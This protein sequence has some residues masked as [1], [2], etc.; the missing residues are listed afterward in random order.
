M[1]ILEVTARPF[2]ERFRG[3]GERYPSIIAQELS[4]YESVVTAYCDEPAGVGNGPVLTVPYRSLNLRPFLD[5]SNPLPT[6]NTVRMVHAYLTEHRREI[7]FVHIHNLRTAMSTTWL[8]LTA[9]ARSRRGPSIILTD[10]GSRFFPFPRWSVR[11]VKYYAA[12]SAHSLAQLQRW[13]DRPGVVV[14]PA[15]PRSLLDRAE[16]PS[17]DHRPV[18]LIFFGRFVPWKRPDLVVRLAAL[19]QPLIRRDLNVAFAGAFVD[20]PYVA[21]LRR[22]VAELGAHVHV[23]FIEEPDDAA[24]AH[25]F[26]TARLL[27]SLSMR[28]DVYGR[29]YDTPELASATAIEAAAFGTPAVVSQLP[30]V[31]E[32]VVDGR[33]GLVADPHDLNGLARRVSALLVDPSAWE[34]M[35]RAAE[36]RVR[37]ERT[38]EVVTATLR[39]F[40]TQIR[41]GEV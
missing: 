10:H 29:H 33:T 22:W 13:A 34:E 38:P 11:P 1:T 12:V 36:A 16:R 4:R 41:A 21:D 25:L 37:R 27:V 23:A 8:L 24:V 39:N 40:F 26:S 17:F 15:V 35:S 32:Q 31:S 9:M 20:R 19:V 7:E 5:P 3:G 30:G 6:L 14:P 2:N 18:D 28:V